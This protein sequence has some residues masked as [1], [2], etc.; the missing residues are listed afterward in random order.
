MNVCFSMF[1]SVPPTADL[2]H[3]RKFK[4]NIGYG[5]EKQGIFTHVF[6][7]RVPDGP[8]RICKCLIISGVAKDGLLR[9]KTWPSG[10]RKTVYCRAED[11]ILCS[12]ANLLGSSAN[13]LGSSANLLGSSANLLDVCMIRHITNIPFRSKRLV[14]VMPH[15]DAASS[16]YGNVG[17]RVCLRSGCRIGVRHDSYRRL[18]L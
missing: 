18:G 16:V 10:G 9:P 14:T 13:L 7:R 15:P 1:V 11:G 12:S 5:E 17:N 4:K 3:W 6:P 2:L 8:L